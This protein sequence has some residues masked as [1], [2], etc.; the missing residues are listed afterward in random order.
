M[1]QL[2]DAL[3]EFLVTLNALRPSVSY[4]A[5]NRP[6]Y[7][8]PTSFTTT[9]SMQEVSNRELKLVPEGEFTED[10]KIWYTKDNLL[11]SQ[12]DSVLSGDQILFNGNTYKIVAKGDWTLNGY[13][14]YVLVKL[15]PNL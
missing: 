6:V 8:S 12:D 10:T 5:D 2:D 9:G 1:I 13:Q 14:V 7:G 11:F 3:S 15:D 4:D